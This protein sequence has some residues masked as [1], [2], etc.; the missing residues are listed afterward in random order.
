MSPGSPPPMRFTTISYIPLCSMHVA[1]NIQLITNSPWLPHW[2]KS[3]NPCH[4]HQQPLG[5][6]P[7]GEWPPTTFAMGTTNPCHGHI[8]AIYLSMY[9]SSIPYVVGT[10]EVPTFRSF[11]PSIH[12]QIE[13]PICYP[14]IH[15][16]IEHQ[17]CG[18]VDNH[19]S[20][21]HSP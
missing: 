11:H 17:L 15:L 7:G 4:G 20:I 21:A 19:W 3:R 18:G 1:H 2:G 6:S 5:A 10:I 12:L 14:S 13:N 8:K 16:Q 9:K